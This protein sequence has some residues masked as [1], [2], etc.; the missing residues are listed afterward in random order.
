MI[1][2]KVKG[3]YAFSLFITLPMILQQI[4]KIVLF[5]KTVRQ[6]FRVKSEIGRMDANYRSQ[7]DYQA[8]KKKLY[9]VLKLGVVIGILFLFET[10]SSIRIMNVNVISE[11]IEIAWNII[12]SLQGIFIFIIF[13]CKK[14][15]YI[16]LCEKW[17]MVRG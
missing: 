2:N 1:K 16:S 4:V 10:I 12:I 9:L 7:N 14:N 5:I 15:I 11:Q 13:I 3:N 17:K 6:Y 8:G